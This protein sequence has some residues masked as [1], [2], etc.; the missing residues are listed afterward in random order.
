MTNQP[1]KITI[2]EKLSLTFFFLFFC[3]AVV[4]L[5]RPD[6]MDMYNH[7]KESEKQYAKQLTE[8]VLLEKKIYQK[9]FDSLQVVNDS[10]SRKTM[11][12]D[13]LLQGFRY[14][15]ASLRFQLSSTITAYNSDTTLIKNDFAFN[16]L[17]GLSTEFMVQ[18]KLQDSLSQLEILLL[19]QQM[20][21]RDSVILICDAEVKL[22]EQDFFLLSKSHERQTEQLAFTEKKLKRQTIKKRFYQGAVLILSGICASFYLTH[23]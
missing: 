10:L 8:K 19:K 2:K 21:N 3:L 7:G 18:T 23:H 1:T 12:T 15:N 22:L 16:S 14:K 5:F 9:K 6:P 17:A 11:L 13:S 20:E 4:Q